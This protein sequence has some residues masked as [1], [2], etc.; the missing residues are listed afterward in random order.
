MSYTLNQMTEELFED[1]EALMNSRRDPFDGLW[2]ACA[3]L[4]SAHATRG[5]LEQLSKRSGFRKHFD[6]IEVPQTA[7]ENEFV[8]VQELLMRVLCRHFDP[9]F[10]GLAK[11]ADS[12]CWWV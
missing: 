7:K 12:D 10:P 9:K 8:R 5:V 11:R 6:G 2:K 3:T 1:A 4:R